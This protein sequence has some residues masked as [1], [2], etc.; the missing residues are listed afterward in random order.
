MKFD[1]EIKEKIGKLV[2]F[3]PEVYHGVFKS[4]L[5]KT[6]YTLSFNLRKLNESK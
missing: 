1:I 2:F 6:R 4:N 5:N 3:S